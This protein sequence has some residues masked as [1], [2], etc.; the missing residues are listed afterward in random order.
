MKRLIGEIIQDT[1]TLKSSQMEYS[2][3][4]EFFVALV[5]ICEDLSVD[6][7][8]WTM[9]ED[10]ALEKD[11]LVQIKLNANTVLKITTEKVG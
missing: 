4:Q 1:Q 8:F 10:V 11:K 3:N 7:P 5:S 6:I 2:A 9:R